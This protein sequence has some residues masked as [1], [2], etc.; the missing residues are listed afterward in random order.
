[1][2]SLPYAPFNARTIGIG[3]VGFGT[4]GQGVWKHLEAQRSDL[5]ARLGLDID[6]V[7]V[8]VRDLSKA[9]AVNVSPERMT[10]DPFAVVDDPRVHIVCELMGGTGVAREVTLRALRAGTHT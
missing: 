10:D 2:S 6:L 4:V 3:L 5:N 7:R 9:R 8:G 1:M